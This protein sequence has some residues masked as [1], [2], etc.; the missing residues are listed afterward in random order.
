MGRS[1]DLV[2]AADKLAGAPA[3]RPEILSPRKIKSG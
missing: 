1:S 3:L 2:N